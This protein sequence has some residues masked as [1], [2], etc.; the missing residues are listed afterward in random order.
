MNKR[1]KTRVWNNTPH[2]GNEQQK[3]PTRGDRMLAFVLFHTRV[4]ARVYIIIAIIVQ[5]YRRSS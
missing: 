3:V 4:F 1:E 5:V 2:E